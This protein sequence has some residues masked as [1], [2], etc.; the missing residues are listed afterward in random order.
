MQT[1]HAPIQIELTFSSS[2]CL[3]AKVYYYE[4]IFAARVIWLTLIDWIVDFCLLGDVCGAKY[5]S[6]NLGKTDQQQRSQTKVELCACSQ[7][8]G[9]CHKVCNHDYVIIPSGV[10]HSDAETS[11]HTST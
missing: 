11:L 1:Q 8:L 6:L 4:C 5:S 3:T 9:S 10:D 2:N 7:V